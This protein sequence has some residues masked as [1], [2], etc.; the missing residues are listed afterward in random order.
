MNKIVVVLGMHRSGT[1]AITRGLELLGVDLGSH[2][3]PASAGENEKGF[4]EDLTFVDINERLLTRLDS[5]WH[6]LRPEDDDRLTS[7]L[8]AL[9]KEQAQ[10]LLSD[11]F[12]S[13]DTFGFKDP[14]TV[15]LLPFWQSVFREQNIDDCYVLV[16]RH[17]LSVA[18]SLKR[19]NGFSS[20]KSHR[21]WLKHT[22]NAFRQTAGK[23]RLIVDYDEFMANP[24]S[25][26]RRIANALSLNEP[27]DDNA[28][29]AFCDQFLSQGLRHSVYSPDEQG[30]SQAMALAGRCYR[31]IRKA[32]SQNIDDVSGIKHSGRLL[33]E[34]PLSESLFAEIE[35]TMLA[36]ERN[37]N[38]LSDELKASQEREESLLTERQQAR[39]ELARTQEALS[40]LQEKHQKLQEERQKLAAFD[41]A[42]LGRLFRVQESIYRWVT[43]RPRSKTPY[44]Q[45][46][47]KAGGENASAEDK[48]AGRLVL[49]AH[50]V[51]YAFRHPYSSLRLVSAERVRRLLSMV[52][53]KDRGA[54]NNWVAS[55]FP[56][57][58]QVSEKPVIV[59]DGALSGSLELTFPVFDSPMVSIVVPVYNE[60]LTTLSCLKSVFEHTRDIPY[61]VII[62]DDCSSDLTQSIESRMHNARVV[63]GAKNLG[64]LGNCN[65][66]VA[67][68]KGAYVL[69]LNNDTNVQPGWLEPLVNLLERD[70]GVGLVGPKLLFEDGVLQEAGGI[71]WRDA[72]GWNYGR[73]QSPDKPEFNYVRETD[74][75]SGACMLFRKTVWDEL[76]GFDSRFCPAY[77]EDTDLSFQM[78]A[79]GLKVLYQPASKVVHFEGVSNG[80]DLNSGIKKHQA[81]NQAVFRNK[82]SVELERDHYRNGEQV[83]AARDRSGKKTT[84]VVIDH[85]VPFYDK[86]AGS[87]STYLYVKSM[88]EVGLNVK[89]L[90]ANFFP[91]QPYT[92]ALEQLGIE[93]L[94]GEVYARGWKQWFRDNA[95][96]IDV[97]YLHR[98]HVTEDF[99]DFLGQLSPRPKLIYFG[100]DLH[101]LRTE[102]EAGIS[103]DDAKRKEADEWR[104]RELAIFGKVD[105][106]Y[107]PSQ[108]EV[109]EIGRISPDTSTRAIPL[110]LLNQPETSGFGHEARAGL[111]FVGGFNH[112]PNEDAV[113]WFAQKVLPQLRAVDPGIEFHVVGSNVPD[114]VKALAGEGVRIHGFLSDEALNELY[115]QVRLC[116]V[117]LR[118]GA[119]VKGKV[120]EAFQ[121]GLPIVTTSI[122]A[123]GLPD[124]GTVMAINDTADGTAREIERLYTSEDACRVYLERYPEYIAQHFSKESVV[125]VIHQDFTKP[126]RS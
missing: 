59:P 104:E 69:L 85:Y 2:L 102:R 124:A 54:A 64:F 26:L 44:R 50:I 108:V 48:P 31:E 63:R 43:F 41:R 7:G 87:R 30:E 32:T 18:D 10:A 17:P 105:R 70:D 24:A 60:Y 51:L 101:Y 106:V 11:R 92:N 96:H 3:M 107:Y 81:E 5:G 38:A 9:E 98:P 90:P 83:F 78:R 21:L 71:I 58:Q 80:T 1:S 77:Y 120:L 115:G 67:Q 112:P 36:F 88:V 89:F 114:K 8:A 47:V 16:V 79:H 100:H 93:V 73:A 45:V 113:L 62:A 52:F 122:G 22:L 121:A 116:V 91:H 6:A 28:L 40:E 49:L 99:V 82:W 46:V 14:R 110:Y 56:L 35:Q 74:Y 13:T 117:P 68:A 84:V 75:V 4:W 55:R 66:A 109:D 97:V 94:T 118:Y 57:D 20:E 12:S 95:N 37:A 65:Q 72:S 34:L 125:S 76:G 61:E 25:E 39:D 19:R 15:N 23:C 42:P 27:C 119:G 86:D 53:G 126:E 123:E 111:L 29:N 103:G 33:E